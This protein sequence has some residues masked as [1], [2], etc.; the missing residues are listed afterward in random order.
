MFS[1]VCACANGSNSAVSSVNSLFFEYLRNAL[2]FTNFPAAICTVGN[3]LISGPF[4][5][6]QEKF[7]HS[8]AL[9]NIKYNC[10][11][12]FLSCLY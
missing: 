2:V 3:L 9:P 1:V 6:K 7:Q 5:G 11:I 12:L 8:S 4:L 10:A